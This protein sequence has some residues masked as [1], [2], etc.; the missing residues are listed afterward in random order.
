M[1]TILPYDREKAVAYATAWALKRNPR[2]ADFAAMGGDCSNFASQCLYAGGGVMNPTPTMGWY[3]YSLNNRAPA[4]TAARFL[5]RFLLHNRGQGPIAREVA[6][7]AELQPGDIVSLENSTGVY[8]SLVVCAV[9][10]GRDPEV[11]VCAHNYDARLVPLSSYFPLAF[12][13]LHVEHVQ[14]I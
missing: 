10:R 8:H 4:W 14:K 3:Y 6:T 1:P 5:Y 11:L 7:R 12:H 13:Y 9:G 2:Y